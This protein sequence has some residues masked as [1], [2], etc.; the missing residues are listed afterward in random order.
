MSAKIADVL[1][2][3][4]RNEVDKKEV[5][6]GRGPHEPQ[7]HEILGLGGVDLAHGRHGAQH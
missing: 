1:L 3:R 5:G 7:D 4:A 2:P 6:Q